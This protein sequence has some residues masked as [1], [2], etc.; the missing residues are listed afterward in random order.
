MRDTTPSK[1]SEAWLEALWVGDGLAVG[2]L[3][4]A[5]LLADGVLDRRDTRPLH[6]LFFGDA[7]RYGKAS[8]GVLLALDLLLDAGA[9]VNHADQRGNTPLMLAA[10]EC[11]PATVARL[12]AAGARLDATNALGLTAFELTLSNASATGAV[13]ADAGF[14]L[15]PDQFSRYQEIYFDE[16]AILQQLS[17]A[18]PGRR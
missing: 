16:P 13:L 8:E 11:D 3:L 12:L 17:L 15:P 5:G 14:R 1:L 18:D 7:C 6:L 2:R 10:A 4:D 9:Q